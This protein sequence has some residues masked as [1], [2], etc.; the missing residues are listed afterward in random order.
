MVGGTTYWIQ[1]LLF[2][3]R[4]I[5]ENKSDSV[6]RPA[7]FGDSLQHVVDALPTSQLKLFHKIPEGL[8]TTSMT[9]DESY[10]LWKLLEALDPE[11]ASRWH[12]KDSRKVLRNL[13]IIVET[14]ERASDVVKNQDTQPLESRY[15]PLSRFL[16][17]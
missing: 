5:T 8:Q 9:K 6:L 12:W 11:M 1:N 7:K 3:N 13:D 4:L 15:V 14:G 17:I 2:P 10:D 16:L